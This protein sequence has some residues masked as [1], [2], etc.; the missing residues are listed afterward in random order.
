WQKTG[1]GRSGSPAR[2]IAERARSIEA[3]PAIFGWIEAVGRVDLNQ[4]NFWRGEPY[5]LLLRDSPY[6]PAPKA[7]RAARRFARALPESPAVSADR[8]AA[9]QPSVRRPR[10]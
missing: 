10:D 9:P 2:S 3:K 8:T 1:C 5:R 7:F 4:P 6:M